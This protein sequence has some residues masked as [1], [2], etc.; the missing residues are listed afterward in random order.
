MKLYDERFK[1][2]W[3]LSKSEVSVKLFC[4]DPSRLLR[5][6][7]KGYRAHIYFSAT[8]TPSGYYM[9]MLGA[10]PDDYTLAVPTP[11]SSDQLEVAIR[12][13]ST[14]Y[15]D[16]G[17]TK[18]PLAAGLR[19]LTGRRRGNYLLF[20]PSYEYM[21]EVYEAFA[22][23][24]AGSVQTLV[25]QAEMSEMKREQFLESFQAGTDRTLVGFAV[26]GGI[27]SEGIDL[28]GDRLTGVVVVGVGLPQPGLER[29]LIKE[30]FDNAGKNGFDYAYVLPGMN[31]VLQAGGRLIRSEQD[32]GLLMLVD[33]RYLQP[34]YQRLLPEEWKHFTV[35]PA[36]EAE[37]A[38]PGPDPASG[39]GGEP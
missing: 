9:D 18:A 27:F 11:F 16:R 23:E 17:R 24:G 7:G 22:A 36:A 8:L 34:R 13:L 20:F 15:Q 29:N 12:P 4:L 37:Y 33:D 2:C 26:M 39:Q 1:T 14:R 25:Q 10:G 30:Y 35:L 21:N 3:E 28:A 19:E 6:M 5:Q 31:K 38:D 32:R